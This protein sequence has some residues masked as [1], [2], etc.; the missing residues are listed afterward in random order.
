M[1]TK[2]QI[3]VVLSE[4][5][6]RYPGSQV[7]ENGKFFSLSNFGKAEYGQIATVKVALPKNLPREEGSK[8]WW[9]FISLKAI[10]G[11]ITRKIGSH[12]FHPWYRGNY[13]FVLGRHYYYDGILHFEVEFDPWKADD[14]CLYADKNMLAYAGRHGLPTFQYGENG[15]AIILPFNFLCKAGNACTDLSDKAIRQKLTDGLTTY[16]KQLEE[17]EK[18]V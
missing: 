14:V 3:K 8:P 5:E 11:P 16:F 1:A 17:L 4:V 12:V 7:A 6:K 13:N 18:A 15:H 9:P 10:Y 2:K